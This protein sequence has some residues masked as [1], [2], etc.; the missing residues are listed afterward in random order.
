[1]LLASVHLHPAFTISP[2]AIV[3]LWMLWY[4]FRLGGE[5]VSPSRR[6]VRRFSV[7]LMF[8]SLPVLVRA[9]SFLD[10][11]LHP[12]EYT[13]TWLV[14]MLLVLLVG[15]SA[16]LDLINT[17][18]SIQRLQTDSMHGAAAE[19]AR[20]IAERKRTRLLP[21]KVEGKNDEDHVS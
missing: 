15:F 4:W 13:S 9:L 11:Q 16:G 20:V 18:R 12:R 1:M 7:F 3:G 19:L 6:R 10:P 14:A 17:L 5:D 21:R 8:L 2:A